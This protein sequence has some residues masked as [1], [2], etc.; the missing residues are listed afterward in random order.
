MARASSALAWAA[1]PT[2]AMRSPSAS[3]ARSGVSVPA[4]GS[5]TAAWVNSVRAMRACY[6]LGPH[7]HGPAEGAEDLDL[8]GGFSHDLL[9]LLGLCVGQREGGGADVFFDL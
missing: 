3:T 6:V 8:A 4:A 7:L 1:G 5:S 2:A 9:D